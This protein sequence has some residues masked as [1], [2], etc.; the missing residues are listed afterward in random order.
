MDLEYESYSLTINSNDFNVPN[1]TDENLYLFVKEYLLELLNNFTTEIIYFGLAPDNTADENDELLIN[2]TFFRIIAQDRYLGIDMESTKEEILKAFSFIVENYSPF[3]S[4]II[5]ETGITKI[6]RT[7][8]LL[9]K[10]L[11]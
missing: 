5:I 8:E 10:E 9:Y 1:F 11:L 6:E 7:I 4:T 2:G 3:W